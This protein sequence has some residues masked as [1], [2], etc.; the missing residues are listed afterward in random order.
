LDRFEV[1]PKQYAGSYYNTIVRFAALS[2]SWGLFVAA[3][4]WSDWQTG[5]RQ[6]HVAALPGRKS[7][8]CWHQG[9]GTRFE[10]V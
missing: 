8:L 10:D 4:Q 2:S 5:A 6:R 1:R 7:G 3:R 9:P